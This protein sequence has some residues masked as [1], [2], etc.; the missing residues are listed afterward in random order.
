MGYGMQFLGQDIV[1]GTYGGNPTFHCILSSNASPFSVFVYFLEHGGFS[2]DSEILICKD[3][4]GDNIFAI[5]YQHTN[6]YGLRCFY[7]WANQNIGLISESDTIPKYSPWNNWNMLG[8]YD[9]QYPGI[10]TTTDSKIDIDD[11][12]HNNLFFFQ[13]DMSLYPYV[14]PEYPPKHDA[15]YYRGNS[16]VDLIVTNVLKEGSGVSQC[17]YLGASPYWISI[18]Y[19]AITNWIDNNTV[20]QP[21]YYIGAHGTGPD[22]IYNILDIADAWRKDNFEEDPSLPGGG[23][24]GGEYG[25]NGKDF[26]PDGPIGLSAVDTGFL[27][28]YSPTNA[29][30]HSLASYMWSSGFEENMHKLYSDPMDSII[31][32]GILPLDLSSIRSTTTNNVRF[33]NVD[34]EI[35]MYKLLHQYCDID[36]GTITV[37]ENWTNCLDYGNF[38]HAS[39]YLP[40]VG[41]VDLKIDDIMDGTVNVHYW[42]D[43]LSGDCAVKVWCKKTKKNGK[44]LDAVCYQ[45]QGNCL[46]H[47]PVTGANYGRTYKNAVV[48]GIKAGASLLTGNF[49]GF[50]SG[51]M[52]AFGSAMEG[53]QV[54]RS[55]N[56][57]GSMSALSQRTPC[58]FISRPNQHMPGGY[59]KYVGYPSYITYTLIE[60]EGYTKID[61]IIDNQIG[62]ATDSEKEEIERLLKEGVI[63]PKRNN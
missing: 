9:S 23:F 61:S 44:F 41:F 53:P 52:G 24:Y 49:G 55:G 32:F 48:E 7:K 20:A 33:G 47:V 43:C 34:S 26:H 6:D 21:S 28:L 30:L 25:Y 31:M 22:S 5:G 38:T 59:S 50:A 13:Q 14:R 4:N 8:S 11:L 17:N 16:P 3:N 58:L 46:I 57:S 54:S 1:V 2:E 15:D 42:I 51:V 27:T 37:P 35:G 60:L 62:Q 40:A 39:L 29:Q 12:T 36:M 63:L 10:T 45:F 18:G 56:Y 19:G